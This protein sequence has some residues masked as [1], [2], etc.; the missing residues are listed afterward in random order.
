MADPDERYGENWLVYL[1]E[2]SFR[3]KME[4]ISRCCAVLRVVGVGVSVG[5]GVGV[6]VVRCT[7]IVL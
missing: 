6:G 7:A 5:V 3:A 4:V 2:A 1:T